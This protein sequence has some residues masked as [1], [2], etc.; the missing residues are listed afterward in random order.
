MADQITEPLEIKTRLIKFGVQAEITI[1][2]Y[3]NIDVDETV[4][5]VMKKI[6]KDLNSPACK[7]KEKYY[8]VTPDG[9]LVV[10]VRASCSF[11]EKIDGELS[12]YPSGI[13]Y[14]LIIK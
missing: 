3:K 4:L 9:E 5:D 10:A 1:K 13:G 11:Y 2:V 12:D 14:E 6:T 7:V 8:S